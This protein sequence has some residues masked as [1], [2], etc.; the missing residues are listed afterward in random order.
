MVHEDLSENA[1]KY[2]S[3]ILPINYP[4]F[5]QADWQ[6]EVFVLYTYF[7]EQ[8]V[9]SNDTTIPFLNTSFYDIIIV[10]VQA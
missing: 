5:K 8:T 10:I 9:L 3:S 4:C 1:F 6:G 7:M 2:F